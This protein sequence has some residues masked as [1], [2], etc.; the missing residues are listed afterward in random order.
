M[1]IQLDILFD[2]GLRMGLPEERIEHCEARNRLLRTPARFDGVYLERVDDRFDYGEQRTIAYGF[3][4]RQVIAVVYTW[5]GERGGSS[6]P[7]RPRD[8]KR[9]CLGR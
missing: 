4:E 9:E 3:M 5:R 1:Y 7:A 2:G 6:V 8:W